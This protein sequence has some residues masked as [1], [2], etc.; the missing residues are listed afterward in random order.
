MN[1]TSCCLVSFLV[2]LATPAPH[3][4]TAVAASEPNGETAECCACETCHGFGEW[5]YGVGWLIP[6]YETEEIGLCLQRPL[7]VLPETEDGDAAQ[8]A[9]SVVGNNV[10]GQGDAVQ[11]AMI[12][13]Y[14]NV[15]EI[16]IRPATPR[17]G[18]YGT[19]AGMA[20]ISRGLQAAAPGATAPN[21][22]GLYYCVTSSDGDTT[23]D[24]GAKEAFYWVL[25]CDVL[26]AS[27]NAGL[28]Q[29]LSV[30][31]MNVGPVGFVV[32]P[33]ITGS[34][35]FIRYVF[36]GTTAVPTEAQPIADAT[37]FSCSARPWYQ[38]GTQCV[39]PAKV[40]CPTRFQ[41]TEGLGTFQVYG[42]A[43]EGVVVSQDIATWQLC[44][45]L[46]DLS[47]DAS[48]A[49]SK[50]QTNMHVFRSSFF[51]T[52]TMIAVSLATMLIIDAI[53]II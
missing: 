50:Q 42:N 24:D 23:I 32:D 21:S 30:E 47:C 52:A 20:M 6:P 1:P 33:V 5:V 3:R 10:G 31:E 15:L 41:G 43:T 28:C 19:A 39:D 26:R 18:S 4:T 7:R 49:S 8:E 25:N 34:D 45:C 46:D 13:I 35:G 14:E 51:G 22:E 17:D 40:L 27:A 9:Q 44:Q 53:N 37:G 11:E 36:N 12:N 29:D 48:A 38:M 16:G 2:L